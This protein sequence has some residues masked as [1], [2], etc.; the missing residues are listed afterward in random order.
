ME[1]AVFEQAN[2]ICLRKSFADLQTGFYG[3][4]ALRF[5]VGEEQHRLFWDEW[6]WGSAGGR[7]FSDEPSNVERVVFSE[8]EA[9][10]C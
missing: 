5:G 1:L 4:G 7:I 8:A 2:C 10:F 9:D 6:E 3:S